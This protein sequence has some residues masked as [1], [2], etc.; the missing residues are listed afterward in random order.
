MLNVLQ[1][2][3]EDLQCGHSIPE[4]LQLRM[5]YSLVD[6]NLAEINVTHMGRNA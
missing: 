3:T 5:R 4:C 2:T 6:G 1:C